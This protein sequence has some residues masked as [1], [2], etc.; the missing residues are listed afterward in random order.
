MSE[1]QI[2]S[3]SLQRPQLQVASPIATMSVKLNLEQRKSYAGLLYGAR[4]DLRSNPAQTV[5]EVPVDDLNALCGLDGKDSKR[6]RL[7]LRAMV[8]ADVEF[9]YF[10]SDRDPEWSTTGL[11]AGAD[12]VKIDGVQTVRYSFSHV[13]LEKVLRPQRYATL[14]FDSIAQIRSSKYAAVIYSLCKNYI[15]RNNKHISPPEMSTDDFRKYLKLGNEYP[16]FGNVKKFVIEPAI[17]ELNECTEIEVS[18]EYKTEGRKITRIK[19]KAAY[20]DYQKLLSKDQFSK[21]AD[22]LNLIPVEYRESLKQLVVDKLASHGEEYCVSNIE[23]ALKTTN[24]KNPAGLIR[25]Y[26]VEDYGQGYREKKKAAAAKKAK[27]K[28]VEVKKAAEADAELDEAI[29]QQKKAVEIYN[30][31]SDTEKAAVDVVI[32]KLFGPKEVR[33]ALYFLDK[34]VDL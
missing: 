31:M 14:E 6:Y 5:F 9:D 19:F 28:Q 1:T 22:I 8:K 23:A 25:V 11:L 17:K 4:V 18:V 30:K 26:L 24:G 15:S 2:K 7:N 27:Q 34:G 32:A 10:N 29:R 12:V 16:N 33:L 13:I 21:V 20:K 3:S